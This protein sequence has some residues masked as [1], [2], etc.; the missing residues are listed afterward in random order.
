MYARNLFYNVISTRFVFN[1][2]LKLISHRQKYNYHN[3]L[4]DYNFYW[5]SWTY[6]IIEQTNFENGKDN[7]F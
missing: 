7:T 5:T 3:H 2:C 6:L 1:P 4:R